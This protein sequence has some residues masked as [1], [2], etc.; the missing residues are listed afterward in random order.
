VY[1]IDA[2][3]ITPAPPPNQ[4]WYASVFYSPDGIQLVTECR[5]AEIKVW[6]AETGKPLRTLPGGG[7]TDPWTFFSP[8]GTWLVRV[9]PEREVRFCE[10]GTGEPR[11]T[12]R[13]DPSPITA[14][15]ISRDE[16]RMALGTLNGKVEL[17]DLA[18]RR[19]IGE[20]QTAGYAWRMAFTAAG[21]Q[22]ATFNKNG[23]GFVQFWDVT[24]GAEARVLAPV[25]GY[26]AVLSPDGRRV[27][28]TAAVKS[29]MRF[30][31]FVW[32]ADT[33]REL[34][35]LADP[36]DIPF[37]VTFSPDGAFIAA[38]V[39]NT[40]ERGMIKVWDVRTGKRVQTLQNLSDLRRAAEDVSRRAARHLAHTVGASALAPSGAPLGALAEGMDALL[41]MGR[42]ELDVR[43]A[44]CDAVAWSPD[45]KRIA[46]GS[47]L[48]RAVRV[49]DVATGQQLWASKTWLEV[50]VQRD[51]TGG[52]NRSISG[53]AFS[54]DSRRLV[55]ASGGIERTFVRTGEGGVHP[56]MPNG[57]PDLKV[58]DVAT[59]R[60]LLSLDL[61]DKTEALA[62]SPDGETVAVAF[63][64]SKI[65]F[66]RTFTRDGLLSGVELRENSLG[67]K[68]VRLYSTTTGAEVR[69][70]K[71]HARPTRGLAF[72]PDGLRL[73]TAGGSDHTLK[74]WDPNTGE[75]ILTFGHQAGIVTS[76]G[77]S[78][79]GKR[80]VSSSQVDVRVWDATLLKK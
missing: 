18:A 67:D 63:G 75:E 79:D 78:G 40:N 10:P 68:S 31:V 5:G 19:Y 28:A 47:G 8:K 49:W 55:S 76:V 57:I 56:D 27:A 30:Y 17:W 64:Q 77:F 14:L 65:H 60:E 9:G 22:V 38:A 39:T 6:D 52:H 36:G 12:V 59:G 44:P 46:S 16:K 74:L 69:R 21:D 66:K 70:L 26:R 48:D 37:G 50:A 41:G 4:Q 35:K 13:T 51:S 43:S 80:I 61:P 71:G 23:F 33:G 1:R 24:R 29:E 15:A 3:P 20:Y 45:G 32:D 73:V 72:S 11:W 58:W 2:Y 62:L 25:T 53:L 42:I 7:K 54:Q 34:L